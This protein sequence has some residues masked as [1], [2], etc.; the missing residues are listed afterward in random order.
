MT[1]T[2]IFAYTLRMLQLLEQP[3]D[4]PKD[5]MDDFRKLISSDEI[6]N[7][8]KNEAT[9][10][11]FQSVELIWDVYECRREIDQ[12]KSDKLQILGDNLHER[13][14]FDGL[15]VN[16]VS[17]EVLHATLLTVRVKVPL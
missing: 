11:E 13:I 12:G 8:F 10:A 2:K 3:P 7:A 16:D 4:S 14:P 5:A 6:W 1:A 15:D 9:S 17:W